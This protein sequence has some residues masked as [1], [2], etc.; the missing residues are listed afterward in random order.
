MYKRGA[1]H[2]NAKRRLE[3]QNRKNYLLV[4]RRGHVSGD[5]IRSIGGGYVAGGVLVIV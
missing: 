5:L 2:E 4:S 3:K 1:T